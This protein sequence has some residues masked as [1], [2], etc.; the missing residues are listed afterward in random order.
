MATTVN[1]LMQRSL[2]D[3]IVAGDEAAVP[4]IEAETYI[5][6]LNDYVADLES[7]STVDLSYTDVDSVDDELTVP[8]GIIRAL[9]AVMAVEM[10]DSYGVDVPANLA[11]RASEGLAHILRVC[12][13]R[14]GAYKPATLPMGS[15]NESWSYET[16]R[17]YSGSE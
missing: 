12:T 2:K 10:A 7:D 13:T 17:F 4:E 15:G 3:L 5:D 14:T 16:E 8:S 1:Q 9:A 11:M 6:A